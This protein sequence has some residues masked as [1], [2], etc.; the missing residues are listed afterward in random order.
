MLLQLLHCHLRLLLKL[1]YRQM[2]LHCRHDDD[3][4]DV[5]NNSSL[6]V[7]TRAADLASLLQ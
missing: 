3:Y 7:R 6:H 2:L 1:R 4:Y 5:R